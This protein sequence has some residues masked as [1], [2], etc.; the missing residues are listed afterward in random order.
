MCRWRRVGWY[1]GKKRQNVEKSQQFI[2][3]WQNVQ[4][5]AHT[6]KRNFGQI[7]HFTIDFMPDMWEWMSLCA[8]ILSNKF[9]TRMNRLLPAINFFSSHWMPRT[10]TARHILS[11]LIRSHCCDWIFSIHTQINSDILF[12]MVSK[13][14]ASIASKC[15]SRKTAFI[16]LIWKL[17]EGEKFPL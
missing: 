17:L 3:A 7:V 5:K 12:N 10:T 4:R 14:R 1:L 11:A 13:S 8:W 15:E 2:F 6:R 9:S 16:R